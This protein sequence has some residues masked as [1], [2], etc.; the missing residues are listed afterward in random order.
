MQTQSRI[1]PDLFNYLTKEE[2][3][4]LD[5]LLF[6]EKWLPLPGPQTMAYLSEA[7]V[8]G[9]GGAAGG[10]KTDLAIGKALNQARK[11]LIIRDEGTQLMGVIDRL[12]E[13]LKSRDGFNGQDK[14]WRLNDGRQIELGSIPN[15]NDEQK[16]QGRPHDLLVFEEAAN[17]VENRVRFL[18]GW[19]RSTDKRVK[20]C[21]TIMTFNPP[22]TADGRWIVSFFAPWIDR[23][24]AGQK[25]LPGEL[26][27]F[28]TVNGKD[29]EVS[30]TRSFVIVNGEPEYDYD[31]DDY[32][33]TDVITPKSRTFIPSRITD[34]PHL[35]GTGYMSTLQSLPEPLRSQMLYGDFEAGISDDPWQVIPTAW[36]EA[37]MARWEDKHKKPEMVSAGV[38]VARGGKDKTTIQRRHEG[39]WFDRMIRFPGADTPDGPSVAGQ[40]VTVVRDRAP[41]HIDV[42]GVGA[43]PYDY[44]RDM[45]QQVVGVNVSLSATT[46]DRTNTLKFFN[47]RSQLWWTAREIFDPSNNY[48]ISLPF[49][50]KVLAD[51]TCPKW[52]VSGKTIKVE[53]RD[54]IVKRLQRSPDDGTAFVLSLIETPKIDVMFSANT[55]NYAK[56]YD[57]YADS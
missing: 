18:M 39:W 37:A 33:Q 52:T 54:E 43:S 6:V 36:V 35:L 3:A 41:I 40:V 17:L 8:V 56:D 42:I 47:L 25:A 9:F 51:L 22:T 55:H 10:G 12:N 21:Q 7:D 5:S 14:V 45:K 20:K 15:P 30:D 53:S 13:I 2:L 48:G 44:L 32:D 31:P 28:A 23:N 26:R 57:P 29:I 27:W 50:Q 11:T 46:M 24:Y 34:N 16:Y 19:N 38:D 49:D 1:D 4:E